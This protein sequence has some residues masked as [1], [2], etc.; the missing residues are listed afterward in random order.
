MQTSKKL[1][2]SKKSESER[3]FWTSTI[4]W[5][6]ICIFISEKCRQLIKNPPSVAS[7][8]HDQEVKLLKRWRC[9]RQK[10]MNRW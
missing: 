1:Q 2:K 7:L 4:N 6:Q 8:F 9:K 3:R 10:F 5:F